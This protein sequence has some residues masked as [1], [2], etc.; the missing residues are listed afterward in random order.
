M[1][2]KSFRDIPRD[3]RLFLIL[4]R[5][6]LW[7]IAVAACSRGRPGCT[8][9]PTFSNIPPTVLV[10]ISICPIQI[11]E[12]RLP[13]FLIKNYSNTMGK[14]DSGKDKSPVKPSKGKGRANSKPERLVH[15]HLIPLHIVLQ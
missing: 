13:I 14:R 12:W 3:I 9:L 10:Y 1:H 8:Q 5:E 4:Y 7:Y 6:T 11:I 15:Q 2:C